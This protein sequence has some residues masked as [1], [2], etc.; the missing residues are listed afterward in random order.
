MMMLCW[1]CRV[2]KPLAHFNEKG[3]CTQ[4]EEE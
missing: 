4:D 3:A 2:F 1:N